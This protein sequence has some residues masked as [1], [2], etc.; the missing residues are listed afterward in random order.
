MPEQINSFLIFWRWFLQRNIS[1]R[2]TKLLLEYDD[3]QLGL[4][5]KSWQSIVCLKLQPDKYEYNLKLEVVPSHYLR[6]DPV[7]ESLV[8]T[9]TEQTADNRT[10]FKQHPYRQAAPQKVNILLRFYTKSSFSVLITDI[11]HIVI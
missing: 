5:R 7:R 2:E 11:C 4:S 6:W 9:A 8:Q 1:P 3:R 10:R